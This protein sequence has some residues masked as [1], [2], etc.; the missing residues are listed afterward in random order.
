MLCL[1]EK[2]PQTDFRSDYLTAVPTVISDH[3]GDVTRSVSGRVVLG[4][5]ETREEA[6]AGFPPA[7]LRLPRRSLQK[8]KPQAHLR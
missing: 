7:E 3:S 5:T 8:H 2:A 6:T 4:R 1:G